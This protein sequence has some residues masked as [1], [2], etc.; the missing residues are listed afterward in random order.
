LIE[1]LGIIAIIEILADRLRQKRGLF[2][3]LALGDDMGT[4]G[5]A[6]FVRPGQ[7]DESPEIPQI[8]LIAPVSVWVLD[9]GKPFHFRRPL[10][11]HMG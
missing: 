10:E 6:E 11:I 8:I 5:D 7:S 1:M 2:Q 9:V 4:G 3:L